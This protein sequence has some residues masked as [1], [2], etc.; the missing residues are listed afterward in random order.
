[1]AYRRVLG[2]KTLH[3]QF[4]MSRTTSPIAYSWFPRPLNIIKGNIRATIHSRRPKAQLPAYPIETNE[5][6]AN[7]GRH[8]KSARRQ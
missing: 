1:M 3:W 5:C 8:G 7:P 2:N 6:S 4:S